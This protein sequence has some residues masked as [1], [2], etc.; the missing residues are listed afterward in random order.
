[1]LDI[2]R[3]LA[4]NP[5]GIL[6]A[7]WN[8]KAG[9]LSGLFRAAFFGAA[10]LGGGPAAL[11]GV[12]IQL[13]FRIAVGGL[14]GSLAQAFRAAQPAWLAGLLVAVI[15]PAGVHTLEYESLRAGHASHIRTGMIV[16]VSLSIVSLLLNWGLMRKG[17]LLTGKGTASLAADLKRLPAALGELALAVPRALARVLGGSFA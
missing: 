2:V 5:W 3:R 17:L 15:L 10:V 13:A 16:S 12:A 1:V 8:W 7:T 14:W 4:A 9:L 11:R 6:I